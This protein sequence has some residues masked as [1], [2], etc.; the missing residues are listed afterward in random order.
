MAQSLPPTTDRPPETLLAAD[1]MAFLQKCLKHYDRQHIEGYRLR[2][3]KQER[4]DGSLQPLED[5]DV[6]FRAAPYSVLMRWRQGARRAASVLYVA[7][8]NGGK[9]LAHPTGLAGR[10]VSTVPLDPDGPEVRGSGRYS[11]KDF[12]LRRML[13]DTLAAWRDARQT[14]TLDV[15]YLGVQSVNAVGDRPCYVLRRTIQEPGEDGVAEITV[16][17]DKDTWMQVGTI[18]HGRAGLLLGRYFYRDIELNPEFPTGTFEPA[19]LT[20]TN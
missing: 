20:S 16:Y 15:K 10:F 5:V 13:V 18:L 8:E 1:P 12:G 14:G 7:G 2:M 4:I 17:V 3:E 6:R 19:A 11:I 9:L